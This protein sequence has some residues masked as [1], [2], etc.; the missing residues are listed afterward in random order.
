[1]KPSCHSRVRSHH[2][3]FTDT[4]CPCRALVPRGGG[5]ILTADQ[6]NTG[7]AGI[8]SRQTNQRE[9]C[10]VLPAGAPTSGC[11]GACQGAIPARRP[12]RTGSCAT[13]ACIFP[14]RTPIGHRKRGYILTTDPSDAGSA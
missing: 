1:M 7:S 2:R 3:F 8:F 6:S 5:Y 14:R 4:T 9:A 11:G 13:C 12:A 10:R